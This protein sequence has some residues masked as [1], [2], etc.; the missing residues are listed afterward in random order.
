MWCDCCHCLNLQMP[1]QIQGIG[2]S[3]GRA[4]SKYL[5]SVVTSGSQDYAF[6]LMRVLITAGPSSEPIDEV[7]VITNR[8]TGE[9]GTLLAECISRAGHTVEILLGQGASFQWTG[10]ML[11]A[12]NDE[13]EQLVANIFHPEIVDAV[14]PTWAQADL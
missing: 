3:D 6:S 12:S 4:I 2:E 13:L 10:A 7:R 14:F 5:R 1:G 9:L 8:S 11:F